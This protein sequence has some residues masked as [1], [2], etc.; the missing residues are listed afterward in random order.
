[1]LSMEAQRRPCYS[2]SIH[3]YVHAYCRLHP[4]RLRAQGS[5]RSPPLMLIGLPPPPP[6]PTSPLP[7]PSL[8]RAHT[9]LHTYHL[10]LLRTGYCQ[11]LPIGYCQLLPIGYCQLLPIGYCQLLPTGYCQLLTY[12]LLSATTTYRLLSATTYRRKRAAE[13]PWTAVGWRQ[14]TDIMRYGAIEIFI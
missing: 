2:Q 4:Q 5:P 7:S 9:G 3:P 6:P 14:V 10:G 8:P 12:R 11:L 1:M 13:P